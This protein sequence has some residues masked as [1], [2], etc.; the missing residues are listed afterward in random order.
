MTGSP[1]PRTQRSATQPMAFTSDELL[2]GGCAT[3]VIFMML[4]IGAGAIS[5]IGSAIDASQKN[6]SSGSDIASTV[7]LALV[8]LLIVG[9]FGGIIAAIVMVF[10][11]LIARP[12][13]YAMRRVRSIPLHLLVYSGLGLVVAALYLTVISSGHPLAVLTYGISSGTIFILFPGIAAAVAVPLGWWWTARRALREDAGLWVPR[14]R[15]RTEPGA[16]QEDHTT[17]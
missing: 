6:L 1:E 15:R 12:I 4:L 16:T 5:S 14:R 7:S 11:V 17:G 9:I 2:R 10:G 3:W 13:G 8:F